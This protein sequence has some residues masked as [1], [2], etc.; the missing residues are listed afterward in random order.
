[1]ATAAHQVATRL[2]PTRAGVGPRE[3]LAALRAEGVP[4]SGGSEQGYM[5]LHAALSAPTGLF[6]RA[7]R[8]RYVWLERTIEDPST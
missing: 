4:L 8:G 2:D 7:E 6:E 5:A 3:L 1:L